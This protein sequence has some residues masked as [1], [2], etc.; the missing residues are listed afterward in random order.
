MHTNV[1]LPMADTPGQAAP[2]ILHS[3]RRDMRKFRAY[4]VTIA[5]WLKMVQCV[6]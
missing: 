5:A 1:A 6:S 4:F 2:N 3:G